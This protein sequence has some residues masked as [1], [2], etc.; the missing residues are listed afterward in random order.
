VAVINLEL[1][2]MTLGKM[3]WG[4][5]NKGLVDLTSA[6]WNRF[7]LWIRHLDNLKRAL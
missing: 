7:A 6:K 1:E 2:P 5:R 4:D 3:V